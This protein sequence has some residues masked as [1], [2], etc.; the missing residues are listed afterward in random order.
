M[1]EVTDTA[2]RQAANE[3]MD[4]FI[5][6]FTNAYKKV[7]GGELTAVTMPLLTAEQHSLLAYQIFRDEVMDGGFCQLIQNGY[8]GYIFANPFAKVMRLWKIGDLS[9]LVYAAKKIYDGHRED[10]ECERTDEEFMAMYEQY[11]VFDD[12][13]DEFLEKEEEYTTLVANYVDEHLDLFAK[14]I[15]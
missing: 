14:I 9:K 11:E 15:K 12:L 8:G 6:V 4:I 1:I 5:Q 7:I 13:E 10:L 2:L 3:G